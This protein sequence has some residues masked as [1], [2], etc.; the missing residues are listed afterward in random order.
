MTVRLALAALLALVLAIAAPTA[1]RAAQVVS[2]DAAPISL[3]SGKGTMVRLDRPATTVFVAE[4]DI[5]DVQVKSP[6]ILYILA[7]KPGQTVI[8]ALDGEDRVL[9]SRRISVEHNLGRLRDMFAS[10]MPEA[11]ID[12][13]NVEQR[14]VLSGTVFSESESKDATELA[15]G[16]FGD[17][18]DA[19]VVN[20]LR[21]LAPNQ[22]NLRVRVAEISRDT[23]KQFSIDWNTLVN[24][25]G[26]A[27]GLLSGSPAVL[28]GL[29]STESRTNRVTSTFNSPRASIN[30]FIDALEAEGLATI[31]AE[32][33]LTA[34]SGQTATFLAGG[35]FP[36]IVPDDNRVTVVFKEFGVSL[37]F[38]PTLVDASRISLK[39]RPE[40]SQ[41]SSAGAVQFQGFS[42]PALTTRRAETTVDLGSGQSF[43]IAG[44][45]Q[46][47]LN[48]SIDK[49][50]G[51]GDLPILGTLFRSDRFQRNET[52]LVILVTPFIVRPTSEPAMALPTD[53]FVPAN[54]RDRLV[55]AENYRQRLQEGT[56]GPRGPRGNSL[57]GPSGFMID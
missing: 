10:L 50:P 39:V 5:A 45:V 22:V 33:N 4:P 26:F 34:V 44:L 36:I 6:R 20:R 27:F 18:R 47:N 52:E 54:D 25:G 3:D 21:V 17:M 56:Q 41:L 14:I 16:L 43:A 29:V 15:K 31:L 12:V 55:R 24:K 42:V 32:P 30:G 40:V 48:H 38:T 1:P 2:P 35:E 23:L 37:A 49:F 46:N 11:R 13:Q 51:L 19:R 28:S 8:Y 7:K 53:G 9:F 57:V